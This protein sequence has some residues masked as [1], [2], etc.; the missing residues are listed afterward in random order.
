MISDVSW[1]QHGKHWKHWNPPLKCTLYETHVTTCQA[2]QASNCFSPARWKSYPMSV[3][4][5]RSCQ[6]CFSRITKCNKDVSQGKEAVGWFCPIAVMECK[7]K[8][9]FCFVPSLYFLSWWVS[10]S[11]ISRILYS[12][13]SIF[14]AADLRVQVYCFLKKLWLLPGFMHMSL[15][16]QL[17]MIRKKQAKC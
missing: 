10:R 9:D 15:N 2:S 8:V 3:D 6:C 5:D 17:E 16:L 14:L 11:F 13:Y 4:M 1:C 12:I 7:G